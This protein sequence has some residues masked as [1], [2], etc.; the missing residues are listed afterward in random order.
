MLTYQ[1]LC[2]CCSLTVM[3]FPP[4][5]ALSDSH[6]SD[7]KRLPWVST[8]S[9][10]TQPNPTHSL[11]ILGSEWFFFITL[12]IID[13]ILMTYFLFVYFLLAYKLQIRET[14]F[15]FLIT[16]SS[17]LKCQTHNSVPINIFNWLMS[18]SNLLTLKEEILICF[19]SLPSEWK[20]SLS[21]PHYVLVNK[22]ALNVIN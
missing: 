16:L 6:Y 19:V 17:M 2:T 8:P 11:I 13:I 1:T 10:C 7:Q 22:Y 15:G 18:E 9:H 20:S 14:V 5:L 3:L 12:N 4:W 21:E